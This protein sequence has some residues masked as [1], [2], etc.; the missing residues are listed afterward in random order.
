MAPARR[1][2]RSTTFS[3]PAEYPYHRFMEANVIVR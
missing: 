1:R 3:K 2:R